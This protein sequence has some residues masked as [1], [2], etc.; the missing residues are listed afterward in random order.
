MGLLYQRA[1]KED[2]DLLADTRIQV[3]RAANRLDD[4]VDM[5]WVRR[6]SYEYY[7]K[8]LGDRT[9][10]AYLVFDK[11]RFVGAGGVSF[12]RVMPTYHNPT[13]WKAYIM[14]MYTH[15]EYRRKG[16]ALHM[17]DLLVKEARQAGIGFISLEATEMGRPLY[18]R[19]G[20]VK[21][22]DVMALPF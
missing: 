8:S 18:E 5:S 17:L 21:M 22:N 1:G 6:E 4:D 10:C 20:F 3:L 2:L 12:Y 14:N 15:P 7:A 13:G 19:Y 11:D 16:I 9:H